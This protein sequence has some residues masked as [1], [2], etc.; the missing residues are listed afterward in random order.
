MASRSFIFPATLALVSGAAT[1]VL[2]GVRPASTEQTAEGRAPTR[3]ELLPSVEAAFPR[4]SYA[5]G[6]TAKLVLSNRARGLRLQVFQS[7]PE[8]IVTRSNSTMNGVPVTPKVAIGSSGGRRV[9]AN[10]D[11]HGISPR[12]LVPEPLALSIRK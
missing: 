5:P 8:R 7:G 10:H 11:A 9:V 2:V 1:V 6:D 12:I 4:E 3:A